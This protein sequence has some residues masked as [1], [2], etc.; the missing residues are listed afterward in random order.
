MDE[1]G[2]DPVL[3]QLRRPTGES[4]LISD[5]MP[6][7]VDYQLARGRFPATLATAEATLPLAWIRYADRHP[8]K[9]LTP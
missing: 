2:D 3:S 1:S 4:T 8:S 9:M 6:I 5:P 7:K